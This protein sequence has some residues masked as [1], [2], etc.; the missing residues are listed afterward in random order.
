MG[1]KKSILSRITGIKDEDEEVKEQAVE[2][3]NDDVQS[4]QANTQEHKIAADNSNLE[5]DTWVEKNFEGQLSVDVFQTDDDIVI[6]SAVAGVDPN[7]LDISISNDMI[8]I[9]GNRR[10][11]E[12][13]SKENFFYQEC[14]WG[15][16]SRSIILPQEVEADQAVADFKKGI[17][18]IR[19]PKAKQVQKIQVKINDQPE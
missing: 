11:E 8:T 7:D 6:K 19:L 10:Q 13:I 14:Y 5:E 1:I 2:L 15:S 17:L 4:S 16:F 9:R 12:Q 3:N 18:T